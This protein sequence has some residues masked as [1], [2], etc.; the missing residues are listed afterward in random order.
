MLK[1]THYIELTANISAGVEGAGPEQ[2]LRQQGQ[3]AHP[4]PDTAARHSSNT[5]V[6]A[7]AA[8]HHSVATDVLLLLPLC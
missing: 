1:A 6:S 8:Q 7:L 5:R 3:Q 4:R 2:E